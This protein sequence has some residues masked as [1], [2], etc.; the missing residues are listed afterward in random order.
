MVV[1][2]PMAAT[3]TAEMMHIWIMIKP[4]SVDQVERV[5]T[6]VVV[7]VLVSAHAVALEEMVVPEVNAPVL[8]EMNVHNMAWMAIPAVPVAVLMPWA[9]SMLR[10]HSASM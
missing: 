6:A 8:L 2:L 5:A 7:P 9:R 4:S 1:T 3:E 10:R